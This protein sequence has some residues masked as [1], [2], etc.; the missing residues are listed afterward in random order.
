MFQLFFSIKK[1]EFT[2]FL[3]CL[4]INSSINKLLIQIL[5]YL[6]LF[7]VLALLLILPK[8]VF[9][10]LTLL[11]FEINS[12]KINLLYVFILFSLCGNNNRLITVFKNDFFNFYKT[13]STLLFFYFKEKYFSLLILLVAELLLLQYVFLSYIEV[14]TFFSSILLIL[15]IVTLNSLYLKISLHHHQKK[16]VVK[17]SV[18]LILYITFLILCLNSFPFFKSFPFSILMN[19]PLI[20]LISNIFL[21]SELIFISPHYNQLFG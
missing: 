10:L 15:F 21:N 17:N 1:A 2:H 3:D 8:Q 14:G 11:T 5:S 20:L 18:S 16:E 6:I 19:I 12:F 13:R 7:F 4:H 9:D